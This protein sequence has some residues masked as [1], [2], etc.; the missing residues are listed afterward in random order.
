MKDT[1]NMGW[2]EKIKMV[3]KP[4]TMTQSGFEV[5]YDPNALISQIESTL[6]EYKKELAGRIEGKIMKPDGRMELSHLNVH[7]A[8]VTDILALLQEK[9]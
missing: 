6:A 1:E 8:T 3:A 2:R 4:S 9:E 5:V 7:N